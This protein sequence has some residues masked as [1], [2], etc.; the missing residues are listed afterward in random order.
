MLNTALLDK[1]NHASIARLFDD[2]IKIL[3]EGFDKDSILLFISDAAPYMVKAAQAIQI[4]YP[5]I[6]HLTCLAHGLHRVCEQ[7]RTQH[8]NVDRLVANIKKSIFKGTIQSGDI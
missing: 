2:S 8:A 6:T 7:I 4:F 3:G 1:A 5:K